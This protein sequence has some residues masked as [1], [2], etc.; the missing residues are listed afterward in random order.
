MSEDHNGTLHR[1]SSVVMYGVWYHT[2]GVCNQNVTL[3][4]SWMESTTAP[5]WPPESRVTVVQAC[6]RVT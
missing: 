3:D 2:I 1:R 6:Q 4:M 5:A